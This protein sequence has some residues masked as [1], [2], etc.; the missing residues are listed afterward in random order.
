MLRSDLYDYSD[1]SIIVKRKISVAGTFNAK[2]WN[3]N[4][5]FKNNAPFIS[6]IW[7]INNTFIDNAK[8]LD[9]IMLMYD[10]LEYSENYIMAPESLR[11]YYRDEVNDDTNENNAAGNYK[12]NNNKTTSKSFGY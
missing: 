6:Y 9:I 7:K 11:N 3:K 2:R 5:T 10:L 4:L 12:I 1:V 8:D